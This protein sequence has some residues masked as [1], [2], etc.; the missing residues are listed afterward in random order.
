MFGRRFS[1]NAGLRYVKTA[2][3]LTGFVQT[4]ATPMGPATPAIDLLWN[5]R[6]DDYA[7]N[8]TAGG[9]S[10]A[11][12]SLNIAYNF[13]DSAGGRLG[14]AKTITRPNPG[15]IMPFV[16]LSTSGVVSAGNPDL[17]PYFSNQVDL[18]LEWYFDEGAVLAATSSRRTSRDSPSARTRCVRSR[19][20][21][22]RSK[23]SRIRRCSRCCRRA[24]T[25]IL[26]FNQAQNIPGLTKIQG[27]ELL[28]Q[29]R[30]DSC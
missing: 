16:S 6:E 19:K 28:Y 10:D 12:P 8:T 29:Q 13:T 7:K 21:A 18:G 9:Y 27:F 14:A 23:A 5:I 4:A 1:F 25:P 17:E 15:D 2:Q 24:T 11:L 26:L 3:D 22:S 30:L 20:P